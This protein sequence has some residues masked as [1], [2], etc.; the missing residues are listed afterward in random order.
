MLDIVNLESS[1]LVTVFQEENLGKNAMRLQERKGSQ[2]R[3]SQREKCLKFFLGNCPTH[4][5]IE[6]NLKT[7][8]MMMNSR[9]VSKRADMI[10]GHQSPSLKFQVGIQKWQS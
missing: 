5:N 1:R 10:I 7:N 9:V 4:E 6:N 8:M 2:Q 3:S